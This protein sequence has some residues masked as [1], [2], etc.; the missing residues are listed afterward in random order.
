MSPRFH[1]A[2]PRLKASTFSCDIAHG[3][4]LDGVLLSMQSSGGCFSSKAATPTARR[5][6]ALRRT[7]RVFNRSCDLAVA[8]FKG[9]REVR[10]RRLDPHAPRTSADSHPDHDPII[11]GV[12]ELERLGE[13]VEVVEP[14]PHVRSARVRPAKTPSYRLPLDVV[15][16][17]VAKCFWP[18][19]CEHVVGGLDQLHVLLRHRPR[20]IPRASTAF[21]AK[22][23]SWNLVGPA[24]LRDKR[25]RTFL[26]HF[27]LAFG[28]PLPA[29]SR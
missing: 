8:E 12:D 28:C 14:F 5:L 18:A 26:F 17:V 20:S 1:A 27:R 2:T 6:R 15:R 23:H 3:V 10:G 11:P 24:P 21:H 13:I 22:Q 16:P 4:S 19:H 9:D 29:F 25:Q 7:R